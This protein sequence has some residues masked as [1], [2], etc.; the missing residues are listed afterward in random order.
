MN[1]IHHTR[2]GHVLTLASV[3]VTASAIANGA[4]FAAPAR[5]D[6]TQTL[7]FTGS[8]APFVG[9]TYEWTVPD[10]VS[11]VTFDVWGAQGGQGCLDGSA[12][13]GGY[14]HATV[15]VQPGWTF[16]LTPGSMGGSGGRTEG[17]TY[18]INGEVLAYTYDCFK[19][20]ANGNKVQQTLP[21]GFNGGGD[22]GNGIWPGGGGGGASQVVFNYAYLVVAGGGAGGGG[23]STGANEPYGG[24]GGGLEGLAG[25]GSY[26]GGGGTQDNGGYAGLNGEAGSFGQGGKG[27]DSSSSLLTG[28]GGGG[29]WYGGGGDGAT[30]TGGGGGGGGSG[31]IASTSGISDGY[32]QAGAFLDS[33]GQVVN[34]GNPGPGRIRITYQADDG[35]VLPPLDSDLFPPILNLPDNIVVDA[36]SPDGAVVNYTFSATDRSGIDSAGCSPLSGA[37]FPIGITTVSC[38]ATDSWGNTRTGSFTVTVLD[39]TTPPTLTLPPDIVTDATD[40]SG[41]TVHYSFSA[42]DVHGILSSGCTPVSGATFP[43]G[44]TTVDCFATDTFGNTATGDF[45]VTVKGAADQ[46]NDLMATT[47]AEDIGTSLSDKLQQAEDYLQAGDD[48]DAC[49]TLVAFINQVEAQAGKKLSR[50]DAASLIAS[51]LQIEA[52][53]AC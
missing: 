19:T 36:A 27:A 25:G 52:V 46:L 35:F 13:E 29:G 15:D 33:D 17:Y 39:D 26:G 14:A 23:N 47:S 37:L 8:Y 28:G 32:L 43:I 40:Q 6:S 2:L 51:A 48:A 16:Y 1:W 24:A 49:A 7:H 53:I 34:I 41:A 44:V 3:L 38:T 50:A 20:D 21:G 5:A 42:T 45:Q 30:S 9:Y 4:W 31:Y 11:R 12:L 18:N 22:G 10:H